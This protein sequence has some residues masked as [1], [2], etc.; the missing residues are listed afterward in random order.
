[1]Q[2]A[3]DTEGMV[4]LGKSWPAYGICLFQRARFLLSAGG[5]GYRGYGGPEQ[6]LACRQL[7]N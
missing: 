3:A 7:D 4:A 6:V 2:A 1:M 5:S